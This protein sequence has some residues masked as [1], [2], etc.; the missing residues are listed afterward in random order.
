MPGDHVLRVII[1]SDHFKGFQDSWASEFPE[2]SPIY[3]YN[4]QEDSAKVMRSPIPDPHPRSPPP[5]P[6]PLSI[7]VWLGRRVA[8]VQVWMRYGEERL[9]PQAT[10]D[11]TIVPTNNPSQLEIEVNKAME[12]AEWMNLVN[13]PVNFAPMHRRAAR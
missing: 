1:D 10:V 7:A 6:I 13:D 4:A 5:I 11:G 2:G 8:S 3:D 9:G 12:H